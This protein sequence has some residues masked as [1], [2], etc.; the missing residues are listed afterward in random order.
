MGGCSFFGFR[1]DGTRFILMNI[2]GGGWGGRPHEDGESAAVS[3]CQGDVRNTPVELQ[4][5]KYPFIVERHALREDSGGA[6][7]LRGGLGVELTY[8]CLQ[9]C[10]GNINF[11]RTLTP[12][13]G[14]HGGREGAVNMAIIKRA[15]GT[16]EEVKKATEIE[17]S[18]GDRITFLTAGGGGYG[19]PRQRPR[20]A[21]AADLALGLVSPAAAARDYG[22]DAEAARPQAVSA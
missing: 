20:E 2:F 4:E 8:R 16:V 3:V 10:K 17:F 11:D 6:G 7:T 22:F 18:T 1:E 9:A 12:P 14:L 19:D 5:I 21:V 13:W 15:D